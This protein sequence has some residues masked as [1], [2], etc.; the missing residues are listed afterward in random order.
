MV[1]IIICLALSFSQGL[2]SEQVAFDFFLK[3]IFPKEYPSNNGLYFPGCTEKQ[4]SLAGPFPKCF[5]SHKELVD[6]F[7]KTKPSELQQIKIRT[8]VQAN[9]KFLKKSRSNSLDVA[10]YRSFEFAGSEYVYISVYK[11]KE[12]VDHYIITITDKKVKD[13]CKVGEVI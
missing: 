13:H 9:I 3:E 11:D 12:F 1:T 10:V 6:F 2:E 4:S 8:E 7:Y 5:D